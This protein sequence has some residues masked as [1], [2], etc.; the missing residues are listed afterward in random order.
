VTGT[1]RELLNWAARQVGKRETG[2]NVQPYAGLAGH[3]NGQPWCATFLVA[4]W[5]ANGV[6]LVS[7]T[8]TAFTPAM[9]SKFKTAGRLFDVPR[10]GDAG[11]VFHADLGRIAHVFLVEKV[12]GEFIKTIEGNSNNDG[13]REG[14][15][16]FRHRRR[17]S[18]GQIRGFGRPAYQAAP[19]GTRPVVR[20]SHKIGAA[21]TDPHSPE[22][23]PGL[24]PTDTRVVEAALVAEGLL[25]TRFAGDGSFGTMTI[26]AYGQWQR[27]LGFTG[28]DANGIPGLESL[29]KLGAR[30]GFTVVN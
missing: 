28:A 30:H 19:E 9:Q 17:W 12:E 16:V 29:R 3:A 20:L 18:G 22:G 27:R 6:P 10:P 8:D 7:G 21:G 23:A 5:K 15:G 14:V 13:G 4:G 25:S 26:T 11:F 2:E 1:A 24:F